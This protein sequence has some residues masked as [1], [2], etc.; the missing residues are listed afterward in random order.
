MGVEESMSDRYIV[1]REAGWST[2]R[3]DGS[4]YSAQVDAD[5]FA[6][7]QWAAEQFG[8]EADAET[9]DHG[10]D[11]VDFT[12]G[13]GVYWMGRLHDGRARRDGHL[14]Q[15]PYNKMPVVFVVVSGTPEEGFRFEGWVRSQELLDQPMRDFGFGPK[16]AI[17]VSALRG[18]PGSDFLPG[19]TW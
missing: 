4:R 2:V 8:T 7:E 16:H 14:I 5:A 12:L 10:D 6:A 18:R 17:H 1:K 9:Y 15:N 13:I 19:F 11:G 3:R